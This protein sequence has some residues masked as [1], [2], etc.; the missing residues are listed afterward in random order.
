MDIKESRA[1]VLDSFA[2]LAF[3]QEESGKSKV[4]TLCQDALTQNIILYLSLIN[5][6]EIF[7][8][9]YRKQGQKRAE[10]IIR[11]L[12]QLPIILCTATEDRIFAAALEKA[13]YS[14]SYAD[15][16]V[17]SLAKEYGA[18]IVTGDPEFEAIEQEVGVL[19]LP[20]KIS[21]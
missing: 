4:E 1:Y 15:A 9:A 12:R 6:G 3:F 8:T 2:L 14:F 21:S 7:Y 19:W 16:F 5:V 10:E 17:V 13:K 20:R 18:T 11:D